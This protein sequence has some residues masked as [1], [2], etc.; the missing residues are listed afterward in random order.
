MKLFV[1]LLVIIFKDL[2]SFI[3]F[4]GVNIMYCLLTN[5]GFKVLMRSLLAKEEAVDHIF[6]LTF[7]IYE[8]FLKFALFS[9]L[10]IDSLL[11]NFEM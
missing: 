9:D 7:G 3:V 8:Y 10:V 1:L 5:V 2:R 6:L 11:T 4:S